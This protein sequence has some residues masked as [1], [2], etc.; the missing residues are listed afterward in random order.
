MSRDIRGL[1]RGW[2][3]TRVGLTALSRY[4][5]LRSLW[6]L[7]SEDPF[8]FQLLQATHTRILNAVLATNGCT[9]LPDFT[10][11]QAE[12]LFDDPAKPVGRSRLQLPIAGAR[13]RRTSAVTPRDCISSNRESLK[14]SWP[15]S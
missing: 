4:E 3:S 7:A 5:E 9:P 12:N 6:Q 11:Q 10:A 2:L 15:T 13:S 14:C 1:Q 8:G